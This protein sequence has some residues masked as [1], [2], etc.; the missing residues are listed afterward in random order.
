LF[1]AAAMIASPIVQIPRF[2]NSHLWQQAITHCSY[3]NEHPELGD[4]NERL[5]FLGDAILTFLSGE[6]LYQRY[7]DKAEGDLTALR[8]ALVDERQ[9]AEF[10][11][12]LNL[13]SQLR[14]SRGAELQRGRDNPNLLSSAFEAIIGAH[15]LDRQ[16]DIAPV[17]DYVLP[18]F[19]AVIERL[20]QPS[21]RNPKSQLQQWALATYQQVP[22]YRVVEAIGPD[23][24]RRFTVEVWVRNHCLGQGQ[25]RRKQDAEKEAA[26]QVLNQL[27]AEGS[28]QVAKP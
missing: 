21:D 2:Q 15:F 24:D 7:P 20:N 14:L 22:V 26:R 6:F 4:D 8:S 16:G 25:G 17:R 27:D 1:N 23:H 12:W 10:A 9:L 18:F 28:E 3:L 19:D 13:G 11:G 5:E